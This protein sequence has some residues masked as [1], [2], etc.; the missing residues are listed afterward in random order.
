M[1]VLSNDVNETGRLELDKINDIVLQPGHLLPG[2][3]VPRGEGRTRN[4]GRMRNGRTRKGRRQKNT[5]QSGH[6]QM[7][8]GRGGESFVEGGWG[9]RL[10]LTLPPLP[11]PMVKR[12]ASLLKGGEYDVISL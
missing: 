9:G 5:D 4:N 2:R 11:P 6:D 3:L 10:F 12:F 7:K 8:R 1:E